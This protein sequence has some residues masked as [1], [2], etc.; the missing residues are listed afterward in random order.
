MSGPRAAR[1]IVRA[2]RRGDVVLR[3]G[4]ATK[5]AALAG[6]LL[7]GAVVRASAM[8]GKLLPASDDTRT[9]RGGNVEP[10]PP[11]WLTVLGDRAAARNNELG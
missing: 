9:R 1:A 2:S 5:L 3:L 4:L 11:H 6:A 8:I 10:Q 7:P